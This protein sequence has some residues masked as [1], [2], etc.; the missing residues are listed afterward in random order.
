ML[1]IPAGWSMLKPAVSVVASP[2]HTQVP[3]VML[4]LLAWLSL[5]HDESQLRHDIAWCMPCL[6][7]SDLLS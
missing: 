5:W 3:G 4:L 1:H 2:L 6:G 7:W